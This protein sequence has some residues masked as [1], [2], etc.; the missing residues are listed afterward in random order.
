MKFFSISVLCCSFIWG[1]NTCWAEDIAVV[2]NR[3]NTVDSLTP[4]QLAGIY[5]GK[6]RQWPAGGQIIV[7]NRPVGSFVRKA[8]YQEV[9]NSKP[10]QRFFL[11]GTPIPFST[12]SRRSSRATIRFVANLPEAI[13]YLFLNELE[14]DEKSNGIK[15]VSIITMKNEQTE[16]GKEIKQEE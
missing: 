15:I 1:I 4:A 10:T 2:V 9:L 7:V 14:L 12:I 16:T 8:F 11:T 5:R 3:A 6:L 13:G